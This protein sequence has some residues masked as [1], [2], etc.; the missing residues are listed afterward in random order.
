VWNT[1]CSILFCQGEISQTTMPLAAQACHQN[2]VSILCWALV[3]LVVLL[4]ALYEYRCTLPY[5]LG[6]SLDFTIICHFKSALK[7]FFNTIDWFDQICAFVCFFKIRLLKF[8][9]FLCLQH[10]LSKSLSFIN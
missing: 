10:H 9:F 7:V 2:L 6:T 5:A 1:P 8:H 4:E 3:W